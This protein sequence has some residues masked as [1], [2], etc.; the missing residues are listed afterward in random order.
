MAFSI[1]K[2]F[3]FL[4]KIRK[5]RK[6]ILIWE[7]ANAPANSFKGQHNQAKNLQTSNPNIC[8]VDDFAPSIRLNR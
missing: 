5:I 8:I 3:L 1:L 7:K 4:R 6:I 2:H